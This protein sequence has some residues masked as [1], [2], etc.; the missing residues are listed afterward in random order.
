MPTYY[1]N[2]SMCSTPTALPI[3]LEPPTADDK[4]K[5]WAATRQPRHM[6]TSNGGLDIYCH[7]TQR[8]K[9]YPTCS[10]SH[11]II[12]DEVVLHI[13]LPLSLCIVSS[14]PL[15][16]SAKPLICVKSRRH[17]CHQTHLLV[18]FRMFPRPLRVFFRNSVSRSPI[19]PE[20]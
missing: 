16:L 4:T 19:V 9:R 8:R 6:L 7:Q 2:S 10:W 11:L 20:A 18:L 5:S 12:Y 1:H 13:P 15:S 3:A 14:P 17:F